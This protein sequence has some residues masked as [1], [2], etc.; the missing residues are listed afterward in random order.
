MLYVIVVCVCL[1]LMAYGGNFCYS[2]VIL[3]SSYERHHLSLVWTF[4]I[5]DSLFWQNALYPVTIWCGST[6]VMLLLL[7]FCHGWCCWI[8]CL[9]TIPY[10]AWNKDFFFRFIS[11]FSTLTPILDSG[12]INLFSWIAHGSKAFIFSVCVCVCVLKCNRNSNMF[13]CICIC[14][15]RK[16]FQI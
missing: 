2:C 13:V 5:L 8:H 11:T 12:I 6:L 7:L 14:T 15:N 16:E 4:D 9:T 10:L 1:M 3:S